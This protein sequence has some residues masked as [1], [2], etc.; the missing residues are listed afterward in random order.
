MF[1]PL[2]R[3]KASWDGDLQCETYSD[4][5]SPVEPLLP[6][7]IN[8]TS[9]RNKS[10]RSSGSFLLEDGQ[11]ALPKTFVTRK[12]AILLFTPSDEV[13]NHGYEESHFKKEN[14]YEAG[15]RLRTMGNLTNSVLE[16]GKEEEEAWEGV[17]DYPKE[18]SG[19]G[20]QPKRDK[21]SFLRFLH[22]LDSENLTADKN[23]Q[24]G[25]DPDYYL[26]ELKKTSGHNS[27]R[28]FRSQTPFST[29]T[30]YSTNATSHYSQFLDDDDEITGIIQ[31]YIKY[32]KSAGWSHNK[33]HLEHRII[34]SDHMP[35][36]GV[37]GC[38]TLED[39]ANFSSPKSPRTNRGSAI[40]FSPS[41]P[42]MAFG[43]TSHEAQDSISR[44]KT[45]PIPPALE[46]PRANPRITS[47]KPPPLL[48][49]Q[50][51]T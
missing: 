1:S 26:E 17:S 15:L 45:A 22:Y 20:E 8:H 27:H 13:C 4:Q 25:A 48:R 46:S 50:W 9:S 47:G 42:S 39:I 19:K 11:L 18:P 28:R 30:S 37:E 21:A 33:E 3:G 6:Q 38:E 51:Q 34:S 10:A 5:A 49:G 44:P 7:L 24:P 23:V 31:D 41:M 16:F 2:A 36:I 40:T 12:G 29:R 43:S 14:V 32:G 35:D